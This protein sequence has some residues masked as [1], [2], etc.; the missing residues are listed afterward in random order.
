MKTTLTFA[1]A[2]SLIALTGASALAADKAAPAPLGQQ[3]DVSQPNTVVAAPA[4]KAQEA[5]AATPAA[6]QPAPVAPSVASAP[7]AASPPPA[8]VAAVTPKAPECKTVT[9]KRPDVGMHKKFTITFRNADIDAMKACNP[10]AEIDQTKSGVRI[11]V[12]YGDA[13]THVNL[14]DS[15]M[16]GS[17][18]TGRCIPD[19]GGDVADVVLYRATWDGG[20]PAKVELA[21]VDK[22]FFDYPV[23]LATCKKLA[24]E[25][26]F[27]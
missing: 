23:L 11:V 27:H 1:L 8:P 13:D 26:K 12:T 4:L 15:M 22:A 17:V 5:P 14:P 25:K 9:F 18:N 6:E 2:V 21:Q 10:S 16:S 19:K 24:D 3:Q 20:L 7:P